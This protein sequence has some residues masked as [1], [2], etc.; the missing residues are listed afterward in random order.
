MAVVS[1]R[2]SGAIA[3]GCLA[4]VLLS[5]LL[6][7]CES[8]NE[9]RFEADMAGD[10]GAA[11]VNPEKTGADDPVGAEPDHISWPGDIEHTDQPLLG[12]LESGPAADPG[13][14]YEL[15]REVG[16]S[17]GGS[18]RV[19]RVRDLIDG[20]STTQ[21]AARRRAAIDLANAVREVDDKIA[22]A[23]W[24]APLVEAGLKD[25]DATVRQYAGRALMRALQVV[26][27]SWTL[28]APTEALLDEL[29][30]DSASLKQRQYCAVALSVT[31]AKTK[32]QAFLV[33]VVGP[34]VTATTCDPD[35]GVRE[36]A[37]RALMRALER[38]DDQW[39]LQT[40]AE[41]LVD[42]LDGELSLLKQR[43]YAA[44]T[45]ASIAGRIT[46]EA[47]LVR[48]IEPLVM[49]ATCDP[50]KGVRQ[51]A[52]RAFQRILEKVDDEAALIP[53][54]SPLAAALG[55][56]ET[57]TRQYAA[58]ALATVA[59]R[60]KDAATLKGIVAPLTEAAA[61]GKH[62]HTREYSKR[63]LQSIRKRF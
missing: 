33:G 26:D 28:Q 4:A 14:D 44:V 54:L 45:V 20:L 55:H 62:R 51:Y 32:D 56:E 63:A 29:S 39:E 13:P 34:L 50:D 48:R 42:T 59:P 35:G 2:L 53:A 12:V 11:T 23:A 49:A 25:D 9:D 31:V 38:T 36:Y 60:I 46:D 17:E 52:G 37:G 15:D 40:A 61:N 30:S 1:R 3:V 41:A 10:T 24:I 43:Q 6:W 27:D 16:G 8:R 5:A 47:F 58:W 18:K 57:Q 7:G 19:R 21:V 22:M